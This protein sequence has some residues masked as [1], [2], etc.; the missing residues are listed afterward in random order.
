MKKKKSIIIV[1]VIAILL[2]VTGFIIYF[3]S[4]NSNN[5]NKDNTKE[6]VSNKDARNYVEKLTDIIMNGG[7]KEELVD[8]LHTNQIQNTYIMTGKDMYLL[9][10][11]DESIVNKYNLDDYIK[12]SNNLAERLENA[13]KSNFEYT[14]NNVS[15]VD[16]YI[17]V[18]ITYKT[19][20]YTAYI[21]DLSRIQIELLIK[22]GYDL[23]NVTN[24][25]EFQA[26][27]Y[28]AKIKAA[29]LLDA[30]LDNYNNENEFKETVVSYHNKTIA[31]SAEE[32]YSYLINLTG[33]TYD[34]KGILTTQEQVDEFLSN[35]NLDNPLTI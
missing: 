2:I 17:S 29:S 1:V 20:Y 34:N 23:E 11:P 35:Y 32:F 22:A 25:D 16:D 19:Y 9:Q 33:F 5:T 8:A 3:T 21:N 27:L 10:T 26:D 31:D 18:E 24:S 13:I 30:Y 7:T 15:D 28:K 4:N 6:E 12:T 14:I